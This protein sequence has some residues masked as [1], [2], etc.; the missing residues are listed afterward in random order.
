MSRSVFA[1]R[2]RQ[3]VGMTPMEYVT[4]WRMLLAGERLRSSSEAVASIAASLGYQSDSAFGKAFREVMGASPK[5]YSRQTRPE[6]NPTSDHAV[7]SA[8]LT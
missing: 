8:A 3:T 7:S 4:R 5:Q 6:P 1:E 2:F